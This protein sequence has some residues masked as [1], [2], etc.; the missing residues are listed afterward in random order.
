MIPGNN[1]DL[2]QYLEELPD[3]VAD[4]LEN[5][6]RATLEREKIEAL[7]HLKFKADAIKH[8]QDD[9][10]ALIRASGERFEACLTELKAEA[11]YERL[12]ERLLSFKK[13]ADLRTAF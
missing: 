12:Y 8:T 9:L 13:R 7:L 1:L 2:D 3:K 5:W 6:R 11:A 10:K 4:A